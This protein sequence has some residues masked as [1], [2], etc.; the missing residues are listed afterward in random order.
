MRLHFIGS[1]DAFGSGGRFN[2]CFRVERPGG[3]FLIDCG[4][5]SMV[6]MRQQGI[7]PNSI[8]TIFIS[9][10][11]GDHFGGLPFFILD[12]QFYSKRREP[13]T[14]IGPP[15]F[16]KR[17]MEAMEV[18]FTGSSAATRKFDTIVHEVAPDETLDINGVTVM[19]V[20]VNHACG[21]PP[22]GLRL[23]C[24]GKTIAYSGDSEWTDALIRLGR[25]ADLFIV[26]ALTYER[27]ISQHLDYASVLENEERIGAERIILTHFGP[28][29]LSRLGDAK[30]EVAEDGKVVEV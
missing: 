25:D 6:A 14:L 1:G 15:G 11:H 3:A 20:E 23:T 7:D 30:H 27:K 16:E 22:L 29:M 9:H 13:L 28:D 2:T 21:A 18:F 5:S 4:A 24:D 17:L 10:L 12:A 19:A 26:E 8:G